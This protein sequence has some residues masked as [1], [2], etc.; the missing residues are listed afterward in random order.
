M[1]SLVLAEAPQ[2]DVLKREM[3]R[4]KISHGQR[5]SAILSNVR[6]AVDNQGQFVL[7]FCPMKKVQK[8][9]VLEEGDGGELPEKAVLVGSLPITETGDYDFHN[10]ELYSNGKMQVI[11]RENSYFLPHGE[12]LQAER[13]RARV[14]CQGAD[15]G[16]PSSNCF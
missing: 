4:A 14:L 3:E 12:S 7:F 1:K 5:V 6:V 10:V 9:A 11:F 16:G 13:Q 15:P 8:I 2:S